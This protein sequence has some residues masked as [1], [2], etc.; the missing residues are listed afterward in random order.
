MTWMIFGFLTLG[1]Y[2]FAVSNFALTSVDAEKK[3]DSTAKFRFRHQRSC[4]TVL[5]A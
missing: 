1:S 3:V 2:P 5:A 4:S